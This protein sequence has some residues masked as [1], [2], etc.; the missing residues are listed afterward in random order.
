MNEC[1]LEGIHI[2]LIL[3]SFSLWFKIE[4]RIHFFPGW[5]TVFQHFLLK[6]LSFTPVWDSEIFVV[7][8]LITQVWFHFWTIHFVPFFYIYVITKLCFFFIINILN[9]CDLVHFQ[10]VASAPH[11]LQKHMKSLQRGPK[12][13]I[14]QLFALSNKVYNTNV[15]DHS[16][17]AAHWKCHYTN[18]LNV[19]PNHSWLEAGLHAVLTGAFHTEQH[20]A[21]SQGRWAWAESHRPVRRLGCPA[22][23][24][25][26]PGER[27][28]PSSD[29][30]A[31]GRE[32]C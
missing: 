16:L 2:S 14:L 30:P 26:F 15:L 3:R 13:F 8:Q 21:G 18:D 25:S 7:G 4:L 32:P 20:P 19:P 28:P 12:P 31:R 11:L 6:R 17:Q 1:I 29:S 23:S 22:S 5:C 24:A 27:P 9:Q 10:E